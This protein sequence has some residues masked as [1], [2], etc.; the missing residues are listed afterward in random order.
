LTKEASRSGNFATFFF[1]HAGKLTVLQCLQA[2][3]SFW[4]FVEQA[5]LKQDLS[6][7]E[8]G[9]KVGARRAGRILVNPR[10]CVHLERGSNETYSFTLR[11]GAMQ[12][13]KHDNK[14]L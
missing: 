1:L 11:I 5:E 3:I 8:N 10:L 7:V 9:T 12:H 4:L 14:E 2:C 6:K 13:D